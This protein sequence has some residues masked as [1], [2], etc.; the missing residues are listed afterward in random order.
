MLDSYACN[1]LCA[2]GLIENDICGEIGCLP[3]DSSHPLSSVTHDTDPALK[4]KPLS[5]SLKY[6]FLGPNDVFPVIIV[7]DLNENQESKLLKVL[8]KNKEAIGWTLGNVKDI[9]PSIVQRRIHLEDNAK[10]Y[11]DHRRRL[12]PTL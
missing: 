11:R 6:A 7:S 1:D 9:R 10:S 8:K 4:L 12:S 5:D 2:D 3:F